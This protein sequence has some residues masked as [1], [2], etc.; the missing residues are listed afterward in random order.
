[1]ID[2][3]KIISLIIGSVVGLIAAFKAVTEMKYN[4]KQRKIEYK[5]KKTAQAKNFLD[6]IKSD[7]RS[8]SELKM[9]DWSNRYYKI[10]DDFDEDIIT[11]ITY[12]DVIL[13]LRTSNLKFTQKESFIRDCFDSLFEKFEIIEH[14]LI[15][16]FIDFED[17]SPPLQY[18]INKIKKDNSY[19]EFIKKYNYTLA[20]N[21]ISRFTQK[22]DNKTS[23][24]E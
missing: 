2:T 22:K 1:M 14:F 24:D 13:A 4:L 11:N 23:D 7:Y 21:F 12:D 19:I 6:E 17:I 8:S 9:I 18:Y 3:V 5:W 20:E 15:Q 16:N 10:S